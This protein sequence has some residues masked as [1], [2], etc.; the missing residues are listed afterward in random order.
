MR[1]RTRKKD[2][3]EDAPPLILASYDHPLYL[4]VLLSTSVIFSAVSFLSPAIHVDVVV[5][6]PS[7]VPSP[8]LFPVAIETLS[9]TAENKNKNKK[10]GGGKGPDAPYSNSPS[11]LRTPLG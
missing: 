4:L 7:M 1:T 6:G 8:Q 2:E 5:D 3:D 11:T 9:S 10:N